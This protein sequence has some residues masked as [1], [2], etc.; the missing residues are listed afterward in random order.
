MFPLIKWLEGGGRM[1][2][3]SEHLVIPELVGCSN[4]TTPRFEPF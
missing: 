4:W 1:D 3:I 2:I